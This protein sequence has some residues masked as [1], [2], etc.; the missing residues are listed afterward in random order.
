MGYLSFVCMR[1][2]TSLMKI[3]ARGLSFF[4]SFL[5]FVSPS[6]SLFSFFVLTR[7]RGGRTRIG[8]GGKKR[9]KLMQKCMIQ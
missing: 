9:E 2:I 4:L 7:V 3:G 8:G 5:F 6:L 1:E